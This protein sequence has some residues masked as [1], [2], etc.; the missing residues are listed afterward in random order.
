MYGRKDPVL[1]DLSRA[2]PEKNLSRCEQ[3]VL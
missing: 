2:L 1:G 3:G